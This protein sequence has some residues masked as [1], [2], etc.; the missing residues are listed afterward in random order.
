MANQIKE[1]QGTTINWLSS[2]GDAAL[3]LTSLANNN[4]RKGGGY[5]FGATFPRRVR[6]RLRTR[7]AVAPTAGLTVE[8]YWASSS[9]NTNFDSELAAGDAAQNTEALIYKMHLIGVLPAEA[10]TNLQSTSWIFELPAR[11]GFPCVWNRSG[12]AL[13]STES[14]HRLEITPIFD[15]VQ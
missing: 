10:N 8:V 3:T 4:G 1:V 11:Y 14:D 13:S 7:F 6:V 15:E 5:D 12:Q 2:G 9:D